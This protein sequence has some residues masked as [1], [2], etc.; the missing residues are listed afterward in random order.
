MFPSLPL[1]LEFPGHRRLFPVRLSMVFLF[2]PES[3][4]P[5]TSFWWVWRVCCGNLNVFLA[6]RGSFFATT[7]PI[8]S[9]ILDIVGLVFPL[10]DVRFYMMDQW[11]L[12]PLVFSETARPS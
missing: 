12:A 3:E 9:M 11:F 5:H 10:P 2:V 4:G 7:R 1:V 6:P 8:P